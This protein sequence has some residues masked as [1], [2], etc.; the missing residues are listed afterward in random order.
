MCICIYIEK[1]KRG[2]TVPIEIDVNH[3]LL[4]LQKTKED[5]KEK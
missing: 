3:A 1:D 4:C 5:E 2:L